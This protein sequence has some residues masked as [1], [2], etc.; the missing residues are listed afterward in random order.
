MSD[1]HG[2]WSSISGDLTGH[3]LVLIHGSMDRSTGLARLARRFDAGWRVLR[4]D[5]RGYGRSS[6]HPGPFGIEHHVDDLVELISDVMPTGPVHLFGHSFGGNVSLAAASRI[7]PRVATVTV[8]ESPLSWMD[9]W[10]GASAHGFPESD[11][12]D[13]AEAFMRRLIG[14]ERWNRLPERTR[15]ERRAEGRALVGELGTLRLRAPW[16]PAAIN[17]PVLALC[18][19]RGADHHQRSTAYLADVIPDCR[20]FSVEGARHFGPNTHP[21]QVADLVKAFIERGERPGDPEVAR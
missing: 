20:S 18:G 7:G 13:S 11:P 6:S 16:D 12:A 8:F 9:W 17:V 10:P 1:R 3:Q 19:S 15:L 4:L 2:I 21:D 5:R 14:D